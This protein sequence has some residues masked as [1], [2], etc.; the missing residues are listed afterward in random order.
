MENK[1]IASFQK[2]NKKHWRFEIRDYQLLNTCTSDGYSKDSKLIMICMKLWDSFR[3]CSSSFHSVCS[4]CCG[5]W[6][7]EINLYLK[8]YSQLLREM[9]KDHLTLPQKAPLSSFQSEN[10][11]KDRVS[12]HVNTFSRM[13]LQIQSLLRLKSG[14]KILRIH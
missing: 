12:V 11:T 2:T 7:H 6:K 8:K 3:R 1:Q 10:N 4:I 5:F 13:L 9:Q 14:S